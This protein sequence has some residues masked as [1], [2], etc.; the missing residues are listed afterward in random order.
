[1][2]LWIVIGAFL[3]VILLVTGISEE[4]PPCQHKNVIERKWLDRNDTPMVEID[5]PD[6]GFHD[7]GHVHADPKTWLSNSQ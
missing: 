2:I 3:F 4:K 1:M 5:C 7:M 6:C